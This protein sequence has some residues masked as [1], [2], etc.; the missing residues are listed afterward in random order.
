MCFGIVFAAVGVP[1]ALT[2][3]LHKFVLLDGW[4][5]WAF[6]FG[7]LVLM[8]SLPL[9]IWV[10]FQWGFSLNPSK[11][12]Y[13]LLRRLLRCALVIGLALYLVFVLWFTLHSNAF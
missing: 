6:V 1:Y 2:F 13:W 3:V 7:V 9:S 5:Y 11:A 10:M 12:R 4:R 8:C